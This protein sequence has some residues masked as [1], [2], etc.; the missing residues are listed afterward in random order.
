MSLTL[1]QKNLLFQVVVLNGIKYERREEE[2]K[3]YSDSEQIVKKT[4]LSC[5]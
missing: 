4:I 3:V 2:L 5:G 1:H